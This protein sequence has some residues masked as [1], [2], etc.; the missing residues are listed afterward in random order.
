MNAMGAATALTMA[1]GESLGFKNLDDYRS[2]AGGVN[3]VLKTIISNEAAAFANGAYST[4]FEK[5][6]KTLNPTFI[7]SVN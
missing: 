4:T 1:E 6:L 3:M 7:A 5:V 2:L